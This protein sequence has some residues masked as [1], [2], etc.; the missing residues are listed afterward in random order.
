[1]ENNKEDKEKRPL[2]KEVEKTLEMF[3]LIE[4]MMEEEG[5]NG[6]Q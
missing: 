4:K 5:K 1:M 3:Y 6:E 2:I